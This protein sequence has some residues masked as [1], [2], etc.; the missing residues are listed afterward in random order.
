MRMWLFLAALNGFG[1]VLAGAY[2][3]H[4]LEV[5]EQGFRDVFMMG[6]DY[7]MW[8]AL[9]LLAVAWLASRGAGP[10]VVIAG[11]GFLTGILLFCGSLYALGLTGETVLPGA[12]PLGGFAFLLGWSALA[13]AALRGR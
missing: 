2:G 11:W 9:A 4:W 6:V 12:A 10:V 5:A 7:H 8:H 1:A 3:Y 13:W